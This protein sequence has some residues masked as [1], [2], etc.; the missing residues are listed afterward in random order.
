MVFNNRI[1]KQRPN[2]VK[3]YHHKATIKL[4]DG[5]QYFIQWDNSDTKLV[6]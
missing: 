1:M 6:A 2:A 3:I 4:E 5:L